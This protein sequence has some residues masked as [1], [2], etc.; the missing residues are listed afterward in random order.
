METITL[1]ARMAR[2]IIADITDAKSIPAELERIVP[3]LP[4][5][6]IKPLMLR[7]D[8]EYALFE[9]IKRYPWVL[10]AYLYDTRDGLLA[11]LGE[12]VITPA[13]IKS[14]ELRQKLKKL[15]SY[16]FGTIIGTTPIVSYALKKYGA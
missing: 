3:D 13:E 1:L 12:A 8:Y 9:H 6:P 5:V 7:S 11:V 16:T 10:E 15:Q 14:Q 4:S 2:F